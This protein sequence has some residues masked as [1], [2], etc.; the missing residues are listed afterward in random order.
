MDPNEGSDAVVDQR[1]PLPLDRSHNVSLIH[2]LDVSQQPRPAGHVLSA[3]RNV[4]N[5]FDYTT[6][7]WVGDLARKKG[8]VEHML[9]IRSFAK[10]GR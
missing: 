8:P 5:F 9:Q 6:Q 1:D 3:Y 7:L 4:A 2:A 10:V